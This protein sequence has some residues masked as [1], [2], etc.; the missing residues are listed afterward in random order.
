MTSFVQPDFPR[1]HEGAVRLSSAAQ[2]AR[3]ALTRLMRKR[4]AAPKFSGTPSGG[5]AKPGLGALMKRRAAPKFSGT[6]SGGLA[7][8]GLGALMS[9]SGLAS[10]LVAGG[11]AAVI[12]VAEQVVSAWADGHLLLAWIALWL[13]VFG[14]L[15]AF[16]DAIR[17][18]PARWQDRVL[19][20]RQV[21]AQRAADERTWAAA[22]TDPRLM[23]EL[24]SAL[25]RAQEEALASGRELPYWPF[26]N[27]PRRSPMPAH[28]ASPQYENKRSYTHTY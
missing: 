22:L 6:P 17:S 19:A 28:W 24:D 27:M 16:S 18:W 20:R 1:S 11:L 8:P 12:V 10:V 2:W 15:A 23:A 4:R 25:T 21:A 26:A 9:P 13:F 7:K 5:L 3:S 14:L